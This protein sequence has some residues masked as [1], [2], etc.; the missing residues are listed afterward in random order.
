MYTQYVYR[1]NKLA[2][3]IKTHLSSTYLSVHHH[4]NEWKQNTGNSPTHTSFNSA[5]NEHS[6]WDRVRWMEIALR[7]HQWDDCVSQHLRRWAR[8]LGGRFTTHR[9]ELTYLNSF[10]IALAILQ[11]ASIVERCIGGVFSKFLF[12]CFF[13]WKSLVFSPL[14]FSGVSVM[15]IFIHKT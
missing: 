15:G 2:I 14:L 10:T 8:W 5:M 3:K 9:Y 12:C 4:Q 11:P 7:F 1:H 6:T 13:F